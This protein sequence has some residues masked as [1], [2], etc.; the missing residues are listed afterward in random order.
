MS[1][2]TPAGQT[3][4]PDQAPLQAPLQGGGS[5]PVDLPPVDLPAPVDLR[6]S[7]YRDLY[8]R[9]LYDDLGERALADGDDYGWLWLAVLAARVDYETAL[10]DWQWVH[11]QSA[12]CPSELVEREQARHRAWLRLCRLLQQTQRPPD[13]PAA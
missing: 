11:W 3:P 2:Q 4:A 10:R 7:V 6:P 12:P 1:L 5:P 13:T 8:D 9:H